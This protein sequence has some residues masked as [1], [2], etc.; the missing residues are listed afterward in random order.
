VSLLEVCGVIPPVANRSI[1]RQVGLQ[2][3]VG[4]AMHMIYTV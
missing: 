3:D 2:S 1:I 4:I